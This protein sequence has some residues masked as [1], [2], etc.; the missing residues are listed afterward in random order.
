MPRNPLWT[1]SQSEGLPAVTVT[2]LTFDVVARN[3]ATKVL[4]EFHYI[5]EDV[6]EAALHVGLFR[7]GR[8]L[9]EA[10]ASLEHVDR[11][12]T[13]VL[14]SLQPVDEFW[15]MSRVF[16][17]HDAPKTSTLSTLLRIAGEYL[18]IGGAV[19]QLETRVALPLFGG[20]SYRASGWI[21]TGEQAIEP[22]RYINGR[23]VTA[24]HFDTVL[25]RAFEAREADPSLPRVR[26][27]VAPRSPGKRTT[28]AQIFPADARVAQK[29]RTVL[30][31]PVPESPEQVGL[32]IVAGIE[33]ALRCAPQPVP[34]TTFEARWYSYDNG[35]QPGLLGRLTDAVAQ[36]PEAY[37]IPIDQV[38]DSWG[39][40][41]PDFGDHWTRALGLTCREVLGYLSELRWT[42]WLSEVRDYRLNPFRLTPEYTVAGRA[43]AL[44]MRYM[45]H[46]EGTWTS[47]FNVQHGDWAE[48]A[49]A[50]AS[51]RKSDAERL[52]NLP[53]DIEP[54]LGLA[55]YAIWHYRDYNPWVLV[56]LTTGREAIAQL[57]R[58]GI[59]LTPLSIP[60]PSLAALGFES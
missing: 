11:P 5:G 57:V 6:D 52:R 7:E 59:R 17:F 13:G 42:S 38:P 60:Q 46:S 44:W 40:Q 21:E 39:N 9:P 48:Y 53:R 15:K 50:E 30:P 23:H 33:T 27:E 35:R 22:Y 20:G 16:A 49:K 26:V 19:V 37:A 34:S 47:P 54:W 1:P 51:R 41:G 56:P 10:M 31:R 36:L 4:T 25:L 29:H 12:A 14:N 3:V 58:G 18:C 2:E 45:H 28:F 32:R 43:L 55:R 24:R 8:A